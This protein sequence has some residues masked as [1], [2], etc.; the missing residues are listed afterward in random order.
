MNQ[1]TLDAKDLFLAA[2]DHE[3]PEARQQ[4]LDE[5]CGGNAALRRR[6]EELL[7]ASLQA[8]GFLGGSASTAVTVDMPVTSALPFRAIGPYKLLQQIG[9]GGMGAVFMAEQTEPIHRRVALKLIKPGM[10]SRQAAARFEAERQALALM[11]HQN[12]AKVLD[13]GTTSSGQPFFVM[14][15]VHGVPITRYCDEHRLSPRER[16]NLFIPVCQAVQHAHQKGVIHRDLKPSNVLVAMCDGQ[17]VPKVIDFGVAKALGQ[18]LTDKTMFT[19]FGSIVGTLEYMSPEQAEQSQVDVDTRSDV[20]S[21]GVILYELLTGTT[22]LDRKNLKNAAILEL[23]RIIKEVEPP[24]PSTRLSTTGML[25]SIAA[26]RSIEPRKLSGVVRGELD[27]IVMKALEKNRNRRYETANGFAADVQR[28]LLDEPVAACPPSAV[29]RFQKFA[30]KNWGLLTAAGAVALALMLGTVVSVLQVV[31]ATRAEGLAELRLTAE[32]RA[33]MGEADARKTAVEARVKAEAARDQAITAE[34]QVA[35]ERDRAEEGF[36]QARATVNQYLTQVSESHLLNAPGMQPLRRELLQSAQAFYEDFLRRRGDDPSIHAELADTSLRLGRLYEELGKPQEQK[37]ALLRARQH[38][39]TQLKTDPENAELLFG[40]ANCYFYGHRE[41]LTGVALLESLLLKHPDR[42]DFKYRLAETCNVLAL[43]TLTKD[44]LSEQLRLHQR[45]LALKEDI[46]RRNPDSLAYRTSLGVTLH[47]LGVSISTTNAEESLRLFQRA[48][49]EFELVYARNPHLFYN[50]TWMVHSYH[51]LGVEL[52]AQGKIEETETAYRRALDIQRKLATENPALPGVAARAALFA[53]ILSQLQRDRGKAEEARTTALI[54]RE[55]MDRLPKDGS[56]NQYN[57]ACFHAVYSAALVEGRQTPTDE[58]LWESK[59]QA[60]LAIQA[61]RVALERGLDDFQTI[62]TD[63]DLASLRGREDFQAIQA[64]VEQRFQI[65]KLTKSQPKGTAAD[66]LQ[67][68]N[69]ALAIRQEVAEKD[70]DNVAAKMD[71]ALNHQ[72]IGRIQ[73]NLGQWQPAAASFTNAR[74]LRAELVRREPKN[75]QHQFDLASTLGG[76]QMAAERLNQLEVASEAWNEQ[77]KILEALHHQDSSDPKAVLALSEAHYVRGYNLWRGDRY[78]DAL[79]YWDEGFQILRRELPKFPIDPTLKQAIASREFTLAEF[80]ANRGL[81][82]LAATH[83][84]QIPHS[85]RNL[86]ASTASRTALIYASA[87]LREE[88]EQCCRLL[89]ERFAIEDPYWVAEACSLL[90]G[91]PVPTARTL[92]AA[93]E[94][95]Q[96]F[97]GNTFVQTVLTRA[98]I[99]AGRFDDAAL[100]SEPFLN[101]VIEWQRGN[102]DDARKALQS[103]EAAHVEMVTTTLHAL[104]AG[105]SLPNTLYGRY[106]SALIPHCQDRREAWELIEGKVP[107]LPAESLVETLLWTRIG[108]QTE[109]DQSLRAALANVPAEPKALAEFTSAMM[110]LGH[111]QWAGEAYNSATQRHPQSVELWLA[112]ARYHLQQGDHAAA[113]AGFKQA[114]TLTPHELNKFVEDGW[115]VSANPPEASDWIPPAGAATTGTAQSSDTPTSEPAAWQFVRPVT[116]EGEIKLRSAP[117]LKSAQTVYGLAYVYSPEAKAVT[118]LVGG[119]APLDLRLNGRLIYRWKSYSTHYNLDRVPVLLEPGRNT[120]VIQLTGPVE[121]KGVIVRIGD[122]PLDRGLELAYWGMWDQ[123]LPLLKTTF[124]EDQQRHRGANSWQFYAKALFQSGDMAGYQ[125]LRVQALEWAPTKTNADTYLQVSSL[126][127]LA[128]LPE[129]ETARVVQLVDDGVAKASSYKAGWMTDHQTLVYY[130]AGRYQEVLDRVGTRGGANWSALRALCHHRLGN[131]DRAKTELQ[132]A[133]S[134]RRKVFAMGPDGAASARESAYR[135]G[136]LDTT[137]EHALI[138]EAR[139]LIA[140]GGE[141]DDAAIEAWRTSVRQQ[142]DT[143]DQRLLPFEMSLIY[144]FKNP[145]RWLERGRAFAVL[146]DWERAQADFTKAVAMAPGEPEVLAARARAYAD[147]K[148]I[149]EAAADVLALR[150]EKSE[151]AKAA[152]WSDVSKQL[153]SDLHQWPALVERL[154]PTPGS[155]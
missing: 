8:E 55:L 93:K 4:F 49:D 69:Q 19:E 116:W 129:G 2:L 31:R 80:L 124:A 153:E 5:A 17:A 99:R 18:K 79:P 127:A 30:R 83:C 70:P 7:Q 63:K 13:A 29:Y 23:L 119:Y 76:V 151:L 68:Q 141:G 136:I 94:A 52:K 62:S 43:S 21:L 38:Y 57:M 37:A 150:D 138:R 65:A 64:Q 98:Q 152:N 58:E 82:T 45:A 74:Q 154:K 44:N 42:D 35:R 123:A 47:N 137:T 36:A 121:D 54:W 10:D 113:D 92:E 56:L 133:D 59:H 142:L 14:E 101:A 126:S 28:Y 78:S 114:A 67:A 24:R 91:G 146:G 20:Y 26:N 16:L 107:T 128:P 112:R 72:V 73:C 111:R 15:L 149:D 130:R 3:S 77:R 71:L 143:A 33:R 106:Y 103:G 134:Q 105:Q 60:D 108:N 140:P 97:V 25:P 53:S 131:A 27:W 95:A 117:G 90:P 48:L 139:A 1:P 51:S 118:L 120:L 144:D 89:M 145:H 84:G 88:Y 115:W 32:T 148:H 135:H 85:E 66:D 40:L 50:S 102:K 41:R 155:K 110:S 6:V 100:G 132:Q 86:S 61:L 104:S 22:P 11:E 46:V 109:A 87:G 147:L 12:I 75:T 9:E 81:R 122:T 125:D 34:K 39:E 96:R